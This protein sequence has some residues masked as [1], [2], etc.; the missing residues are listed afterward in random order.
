[1]NKPRSIAKN[2]IIKLNIIFSISLILIF[3][4]TYFVSENEINQ[5]FDAE[6]KKSALVIYEIAKHHHLNS[7]SPSLEEKLH[8]KF[9]NRYDY[10]IIF[11]VWNKENLIYN[12]NNKIIF[13][14]IEKEGF[15]NINNGEKKWR[16]FIY[17][18]QINHLK[19]AIF[20][21]YKIRKNLILEISTTIFF[22]IFAFLFI[23]IVLIIKITNKEL[24]P[25]HNLSN[26]LTTISLSKF[27]I[28]D[29]EKYP[30]EIRPLIFSFNQLMLKL[31]QILENEKRF[32]NHVAHELS[33][34]LTAIRLQAEI[35]QDNYHKNQL[36][37]FN[38]IITAVDRTSHLINQILVLSRIESEI[39]KRNF[40]YYDIDNLL[41]EIIDEF[42]NNLK[43]K[44]FILQKEFDFS[45]TKTPI[46]I[47]KTY[48][49]IMINNILDNAIKYNLGE[50]PIKFFVSNNKKHLLIKITN[51]SENI[52]FEDKNKIFTKFFRAN[53]DYQ[54]KHVK[55]CGLGLNIV[56][57]IVKIHDGKISF[58][59]KDHK[60]SVTIEFKN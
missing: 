14:N 40:E 21:N 57:Q 51:K 33:T 17:I 38:N 11:Q 19:I 9:F 6:L 56:K 36:I 23:T 25:I 35:L 53:K 5:I 52:K 24:K 15:F 7:D 28:I 27:E 45:L 49:K 58:E 54:T 43:N 26:K 55:G 60:T 12:S 29:Q 32:T 30:F 44:K 42:E 20:E 47:N 10:D 22:I 48:F 1:M 37:S 2:L 41:N 13:D 31:Q 16:N 50:D 34:P 39:D 8:Y 3:S 59:N 4:T 18:D 46:K